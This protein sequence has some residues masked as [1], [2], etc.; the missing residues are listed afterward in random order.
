MSEEQKDRRTP[1]PTLDLFIQQVQDHIEEAR[2]DRI[3]M[4]KSIK[5]LHD[6]FEAFSD[7]YTPVLDKTIAQNLFWGGL[8]D[9]MIKKGVI[10]ALVI[11]VVGVG[12]GFVLWMKTVFGVMPK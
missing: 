7:K 5:C 2:T 8:R 3:A 4:L 1:D 10:T 9:D 12:G 6:V 11:V